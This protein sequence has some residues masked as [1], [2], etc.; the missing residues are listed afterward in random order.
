LPYHTVVDK[1]TTRIA[2]VPVTAEISNQSQLS[3][4]KPA[5]P[6]PSNVVVV[7]PFVSAT[8]SVFIILLPPEPIVSRSSILKAA[9]VAEVT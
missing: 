1:V 9:E 6:A 2:G 8:W 4:A 3:A 7:S 5:P